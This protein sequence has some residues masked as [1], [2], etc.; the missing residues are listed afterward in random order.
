MP[1]FVG[2]ARRHIHTLNTIP[3]DILLQVIHQLALLESCGPPSSIF[4]S[5]LQTCKALASLESLLL[6]SIAFK[7]QFDSHAVER[8]LPS[9]A[10]TS[11]SLMI[12]TKRRWKCLRRIRWASQDV[13]LWKSAYT[14]EQK[15]E[16]MWTAF[17]ML[18]EN[19][20]RNWKQL[21]WAHL[22]TYVQAF[23]EW[24][25]IPASEGEELP[26]ETEERALGLWL[27]WFLSDTGKVFSNGFRT[28]RP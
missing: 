17:L 16:D 23:V 12:E 1:A 15:R 10:M 6:Y 3:T 5:L 19:D 18:L 8:R 14:L 25:L 27:L 9:A 20:G 2:H 28:N 4:V 24:D 11:S 7:G 22:H 26:P 13:S 21:T